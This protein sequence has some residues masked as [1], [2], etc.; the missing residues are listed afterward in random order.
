M[1]YVGYRTIKMTL[2]M[3]FLVGNDADLNSVLQVLTLAAVKHLV[4]VFLDLYRRVVNP[5]VRLD[6]Q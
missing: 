1:P 4:D 2:V 3:L 5:V 6:Q